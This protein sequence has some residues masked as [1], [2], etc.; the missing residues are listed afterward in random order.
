MRV[1]FSLITL[2]LATVAARPSPALRAAATPDVIAA[3]KKRAG[4]EPAF[5]PR[6][7]A[8]HGHWQPSPELLY[9]P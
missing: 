4:L 5:A 7:C 3:A 1:K 2:L 9:F 8:L 6:F